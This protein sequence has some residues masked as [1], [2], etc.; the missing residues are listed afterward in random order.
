M[1]PVC[2]KI[3]DQEQKRPKL[4]PVCQKL[5]DQEHPP[6]FSVA[7]RDHSP[8][9]RGRPESPSTLPPRFNGQGLILCLGPCPHFGL[10]CT[11]NG[12]GPHPEIRPCPSE[13][14]LFTLSPLSGLSNLI[15]S[16]DLK[17]K[18]PKRCG[19]EFFVGAWNKNGQ[20]RCKFRS[21]RKEV[22][23]KRCRSLQGGVR[24]VGNA[25]GRSRTGSYG[26]AG[27]GEQHP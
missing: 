9:R 10:P 23:Q 16:I 1:F 19:H 26:G 7:G 3:A 2:Q 27:C 17:Q 15:S 11:F 25:A 4:F 6:P 20:K 18:Q 22:E 21:F 5:A 8:L 13:G 14:V 24:L 12:Q